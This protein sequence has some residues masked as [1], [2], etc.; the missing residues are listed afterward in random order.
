MKN[1]LT[2]RANVR[3]PSAGAESVNATYFGILHK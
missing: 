1:K 2:Y 3:P